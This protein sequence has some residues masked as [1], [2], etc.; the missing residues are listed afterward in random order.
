MSFASPTGLLA[1]LAVPVLLG[2]MRL[3]TRRRRRFAMR[4]PALLALVASATPRPAWRRRLPA[5]LLTLG[6][7]GLAVALARPRVPVW[8]PVERASIL[9]VTDR[10]GSMLAQDVSPSRITAAQA[11][12]R[13]FLQEVP[14]R[15]RVGALSYS[16]GAE[17]QVA[18]TTDRD[19]VTSA[20][21]ALR[22]EGGTATGDA[23]A[24]A[25]E[26]LRAQQRSRIPA[27]IVLLSDGATTAGRD[28]VAVARTAAKLRIPISTIALGTDAGTVTGPDGLPVRVPPDPATLREIATRS[29]GKA[30]AADDADGLSG[31]YRDLGSRLGRKRERREVTAGVAVAG[32][33]LLTGGLTGSLRRRPVLA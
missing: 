17:L 9:L 12:A 8:V 32:L 11:A 3:A 31:V 15:V 10:S 27:A 23:L 7:A 30:F 14:A 25:V 26:A 6:V 4:Y 2:A 13:Q 33:V 18:P 1:L 28:P 5:A 24:L 16:D 21:G 29:G 20:L 22:A 19:A